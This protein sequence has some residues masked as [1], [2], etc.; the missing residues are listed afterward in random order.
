M[1]VL[2]ARILSAGWAFLLR[3]VS[4]SMSTPN[5]KI[6]KITMRVPMKDHH[7]SDKFLPIS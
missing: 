2:V 5:S 1:Y 3:R 4:S 7:E 6:D